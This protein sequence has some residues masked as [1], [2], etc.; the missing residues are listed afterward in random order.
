MP[1]DLSRPLPD[2][3]NADEAAMLAQLQGNILK[4]H[5][6]NRT[7]HVFLRVRRG[8]AQQAR[9]FLRAYAANKL[10]S[11]AQQLEAA[12]AFKKDGPGTT[13]PLVNRAFVAVMFSAAGYRALGI[14]DA[15]MPADPAFR[16]GLKA[17]GPQLADPAVNKWHK[18]YRGELHAMILIGG[19]ADADHSATSTFI[20]AE[21][22]EL[23][24]HAPTSGLTLVGLERGRGYDN[25][26]GVGL[27]HF[28]YVDG[29]S[30][31][32]MLES[33]IARELR[34][35]AG[36]PLW[37]P[38][39]PLKQVLVKD[40]AVPDANA[41]GSY[42]VFRKLEQ[43][44]KGFVAAEKTLQTTL[45]N[46]AAQ[47]GK[48]FKPDLAGAMLVG[49][50]RDG[51]PVS[52]SDHATGGPVNNN[53]GFADDMAG[54]KCPFHAHIRKTNPRG[55][56]AR[57]FSSVTEAAEREHIMARRGIT[58]G[59]RRQRL[60]AFLDQPS[61]GVGLLF[62]AYQRDIAKQFEF[63]QASWANSENFVQGLTGVDVILGQ[64]GTLPQKHRAAWNDASAPIHQQ[65]FADF[66]SMKGGEYFFAPS[67]PFFATL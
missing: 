6:R 31:P 66:V 24:S 42:F 22:A 19:R 21:L 48:T 63:T 62:M 15:A 54:A 27:E 28:G 2:N 34:G 36:P 30:Q 65:L 44:V 37:S 17:R 32:L 67:L 41:F 45:E 52:T 1:I 4:G 25:A 18:G 60:G 5:G 3:R 10:M 9:A 33:D 64:G 58:Y 61:K 14:A 55:D 46:A 40:P 49:R 26:D 51:T 29:R 8:R 35:Q 38:A 7:A 16:D 20:E 39:F 11:A 56:S 13:N 50:F 57:V 59:T 23:A 47:A 43:N 12:A 53:F